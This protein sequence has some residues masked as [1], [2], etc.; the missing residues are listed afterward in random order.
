MKKLTYDELIDQ[1]RDYL[2]MIP[3]D[4]VVEVHNNIQYSLYGYSKKLICYYP[5]DADEPTFI[6]M[7]AEI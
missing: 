4:E 7:E 5:D 6:E 2:A 3:Y 1:I